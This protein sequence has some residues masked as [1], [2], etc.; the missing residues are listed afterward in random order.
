MSCTELTHKVV[1]QRIRHQCVWC[2]E[3][4][5]DMAVYRSYIFEGDFNSDYMHLECEEAMK[6]TDLR[7]QDDGFEA[8][9]NDRPK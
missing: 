7:D 4:I 9:V 1:K 2:G 8:Y 5:Q 3:I 6:N